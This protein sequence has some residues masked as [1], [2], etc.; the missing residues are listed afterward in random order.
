M[1]K[2][3]IAEEGAGEVD[4]GLPW[5]RGWKIRRRGRDRAIGRRRCET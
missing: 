4:E 3:K 1:I 5:V 2:I